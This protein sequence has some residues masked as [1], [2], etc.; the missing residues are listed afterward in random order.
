MIALDDNARAL[1]L[2]CL[3]HKHSPDE[4][5]RILDA[6]APAVLL[7]NLRRAIANHDYAL[8][9]MHP[10]HPRRPAIT[11]DRAQLVALVEQ[12]AGAAKP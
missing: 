9:E 3:E 6:G 1:I 12:L 5:R 7:A 4:A 11:L 8:M 2:A 10:L